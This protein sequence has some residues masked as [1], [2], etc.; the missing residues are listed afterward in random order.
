MQLCNFSTMVAIWKGLESESV[1]RLVRANG[2]AMQVYR[3]AVASLG[4][5]RAFKLDSNFCANRRRHS[6]CDE[7]TN[8]NVKMCYGT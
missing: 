6:C 5:L 2:E 4:N 8:S 7:R 3:L 1:R